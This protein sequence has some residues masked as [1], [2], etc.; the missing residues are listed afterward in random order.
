MVSTSQAFVP[1]VTKYRSLKVSLSS[2]A[3]AFAAVLP[4]LSVTKQQHVRLLTRTFGML[5]CNMTNHA[6]MAHPPYVL[7]WPTL[8]LRTTQRL[9]GAPLAGTLNTQLSHS[10]S[11]GVGYIW[12]KPYADFCRPKSDWLPGHANSRMIVPA[13]RGDEL[14]NEDDDAVRLELLGSSLGPVLHN[15]L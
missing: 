2:S 11:L 13:G 5:L 4:S 10:V 3:A 7:T 9:Q 12:R 1:P 6:D 14:V 8:H 15:L